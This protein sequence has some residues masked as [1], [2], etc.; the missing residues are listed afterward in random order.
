MSQVGG[1][2]FDFKLFLKV[3]AYA[4]PYRALFIFAV[5][6][7]IALGGLGTAR[8]ILIRSVIDDERNAIR[9]E[10]SRSW[11]LLLLQLILRDEGC[12][13]TFGLLRR[14]RLWLGRG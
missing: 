1:K 7:T 10:R 14:L 13:S 8:P 6:L 5:F 9:L 11:A 3:M 4:R 12:S 2:A